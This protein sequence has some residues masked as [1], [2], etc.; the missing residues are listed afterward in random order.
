M[1][2]KIKNIHPETLI[3]PTDAYVPRLYFDCR[4]HTKKKTHNTNMER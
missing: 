1:E 4:L 2:T 3:S